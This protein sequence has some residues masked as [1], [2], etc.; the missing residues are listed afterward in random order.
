MGFSDGAFSGAVT[1]TR[2]LFGAENRRRYVAVGVLRGERPV[3][4]T[5]PNVLPALAGQLRARTLHLLS[6]AVVVEVILEIDGLGDLLWK[7][8]LE[9]DFPIML[10][11]A[12]CFALISAVLLVAQSVLEIGVAWHIRR[13]PRIPAQE[14]AS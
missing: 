4:N 1:G 11:A 13:S 8:T 9:Q 5:L 6:G 3:S 10:A 12:T 14:V 2:S 7:G